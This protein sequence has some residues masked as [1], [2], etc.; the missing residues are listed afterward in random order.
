MEIVDLIFEVME[1]VYSTDHFVI[2]EN[3]QWLGAKRRD[4]DAIFDAYVDTPDRKATLKQKMQQVISLV[5]NSDPVA[6]CKIVAPLA[7]IKLRMC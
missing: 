4:L 6:W 3:L 1:G 2:S 5:E 7:H